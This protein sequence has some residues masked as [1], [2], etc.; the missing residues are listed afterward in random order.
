[1]TM[2]ARPPGAIAA[3]QKNTWKNKDAKCTTEPCPLAQSEKKIGVVLDFH[4]VLFKKNEN[5]AEQ[6]D[7]YMLTQPEFDDFHLFA[8]GRSE[9][10]VEVQLVKLNAKGNV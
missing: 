3:T 6:E 9:A 1:M 8:D 7:F 10:V 4:P 2:D 5:P